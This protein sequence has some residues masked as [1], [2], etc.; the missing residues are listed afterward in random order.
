MIED[1][2][3]RKLLAKISRWRTT[4]DNGDKYHGLDEYL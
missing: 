1:K 2:D 4:H 3:N